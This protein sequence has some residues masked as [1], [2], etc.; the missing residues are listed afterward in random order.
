MHDI[1]FTRTRRDVILTL[2]LGELKC[3]NTCL[4][5]DLFVTKSQNNSGSFEIFY[6]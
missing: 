1:G 5:N 3:R 6:Y 2:P 4:E